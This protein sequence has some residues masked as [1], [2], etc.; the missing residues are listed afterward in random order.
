MQRSHPPPTCC[1]IIVAPVS[2]YV[3]PCRRSA[4]PTSARSQ[5]DSAPHRSIASS[6]SGDVSGRIRRP[7][8]GSQDRRIDP[9]VRLWSVTGGDVRTAHP[10]P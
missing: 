6:S 10:P 8:V 9:S 1:G 5:R 2:P 7:Y 3:H 4:R